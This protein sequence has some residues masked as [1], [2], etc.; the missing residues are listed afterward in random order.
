MKPLSFLPSRECAPICGILTDIDDTL[1]TDGAITPD[2]LQALGALKASGLHVIPITGRPVGWSE[3]FAATWPVDAIVAEN[4]AVALQRSAEVFDQKSLLP[5]HSKREQ[6]SKI[7]QQDAATRAANYANMQQVLAQIER[8]VPGA[9]RATDSPG[10]E[11][12][13]AI[14][15]SEFTHLPQ[16]A[17]DHAVRIMR[18]AGMNATV[19]SI[20]ING[21]FGAHNKLEGARWIVRELFGRNLDAEID[22]WVY[23]G[24]STNDQVMFEH[25]PHSVG[26]ANI[27]RFV[28]QLTHRPRFVTQGERGAG[29]AEVARAVLAAR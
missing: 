7:Y 9:R 28:P 1:T 26:V 5:N 6:L 23:V 21:W 11:T 18:N 13:I 16:D 19:S 22:R 25:F 10:R 17:I 12:D 14:D 4:G 15:H 8:E 27:A 2:A 20:H 3:P 29:F 24:D